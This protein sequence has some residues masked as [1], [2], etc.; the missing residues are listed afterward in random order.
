MPKITV[1]CLYTSDWLDIAKIV[2]PNLVSYCGKHGYNWNV[3]CVGEKYNHFEKIKQIKKTF[4][5]NEADYVMSIDCDATFTNH[6]I[7]IESIIDEQHSF[8]ITEDVH[9]INGGVFI[10]KNNQ[11]CKEFLDYILS[12]EGVAN[13]EQDAISLFMADNP[14]DTNIAILPQRIM[15]TYLYENYPQYG[16]QTEEKGQW[17]ECKSFILHLPGIGMNERLNIL[18][19]TPIAK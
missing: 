13:C 9:G 7:T 10:A 17:I 1:Q 2:I 14:E 12:F 3:Q 5:N 4:E 19:N 18:K 16:I 15:N 6:T 11:W 8:W